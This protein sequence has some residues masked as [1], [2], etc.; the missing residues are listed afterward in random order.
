M[1]KVLVLVLALAMLVSASAALAEDVSALS[2][3][4][5]A[6]LY[7]RVRHELTER[8]ML[9]EDTGS[10][11][12]VETLIEYTARAWPI[13]ED[14]YAE[15]VE[16]IEN[17]IGTVYFVRGTVGEV[18]EE[19]LRRATVFAGG[20]ESLPVV[21]EIPVFSSYCPEPG[22]DVRVYGEAG[23]LINGRPRLIGRYIFPE[24]DEPAGAEEGSGT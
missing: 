6:D 19:G 9:S 13:T 16:N 12:P 5:L 4:E 8:G 3:E 2:D 21:V 1:K 14:T 11:P 17:R 20:D 23:I 22:D 24:P 7:N 10:I 18:S 15:L